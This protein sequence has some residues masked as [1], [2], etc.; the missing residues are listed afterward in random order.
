MKEKRELLRHFLAAL[1]Y[2]TQKSLR[3]APAEYVIFDA[4]KK[5]RTPHEIVCHMN[6]V[7]GYALTF[8]E[9][10]VYRAEQ[11]PEFK[12]EVARLHTTI[13][14]LS[15]HLENGTPLQG[16]SHEQIL[17]GP[18]ADAM[19]HVGQLAMLRRLSGTP[20]PPENFSQADIQADNVGMDQAR[21][22]KPGNRRGDWPEGPGE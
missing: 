18:F 3:E 7:L 4:G 6:S 12:N 21:P 1:A 10:G 11:L 14:S 15:T 22:N 16:I 20:V 19:T 5:V 8:F 17:Q 2:R 13:G 9:G